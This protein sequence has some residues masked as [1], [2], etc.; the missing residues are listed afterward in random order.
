MN[1]INKRTL[2]VFTVLSSTSI[3]AGPYGYDLHNTLAPAAAGMAGTSIAKSPDTVSAV[4]GNPATL[5][6]YEGTQFTFGATFYMPEVDLTHDGSV[7]GTAFNE[8]KSGTDIFPVPQIA[9]TQD[10]RGLN[11]PATIGL[12]LTA[13]S[14]IGAEFRKTPGSLGAGAEFIIFGVN[15]GLGYEITDNLSVGGAAT[16]SFAQMDLGLSSTGAQTHD[17]GLRATLGATYDIGKTTI[18]A[19]YQTKQDHKFDSLV[20]VTPGVYDDTRISQPANFGIGISNESLMDGN[21]LLSADF[22]YKQWDDADF[23]QDIYENQKVYSLGAQ[24]TKGNWKYRL[25]YGYADDP[26]KENVTAGIGS[27]GSVVTNQFGQIPVSQGVVEYLQAAE[28]E[29]IYKHRLTAGLGYQNMLGVKGL[30]L[31]AHVGYQFEESREYGTGS[32]AGGGHTRAD[33]SSWHTGFGLTWKF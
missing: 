30:D 10:L 24:L 18:G 26:T 25:G 12:G 20:E 2:V 28:A 5:A 32:L 11:I 33:V 13:T 16:I 14:G 15:A 19:F 1:L 3:F 4:F 6:D 22:I 8:A 17:L 7:T 9:V 31:D 27:L 23:W 21:L 29:V